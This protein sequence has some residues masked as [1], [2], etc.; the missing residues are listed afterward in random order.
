MECHLVNVIKTPAPNFRMQLEKQTH[1]QDQRLALV[2]LLSA[3]ELV[4]NWI[5]IDAEERLDVRKVERKILD[6][7]DV[8]HV[9]A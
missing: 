9:E 4:E 5:G 6:C 1:G 8:V 3:A 2:N 7:F